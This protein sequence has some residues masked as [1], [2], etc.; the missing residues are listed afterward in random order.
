MVVKKEDVPE[1]EV[2]PLEGAPD[3]GE[4]YAVM[5]PTRLQ[6]S[7]APF[8]PAHWSLCARQRCNQSSQNILG[9]FQVFGG[10]PSPNLLMR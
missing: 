1:S 7:T 8:D 10:I 2:L 4:G 6:P 5:E 3:D 9:N